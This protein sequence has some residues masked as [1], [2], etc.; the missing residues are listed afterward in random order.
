M[1]RFI[2]RGLSRFTAAGVA[3]SLPLTTVLLSTH[4]LTEQERQGILP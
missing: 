3:S 2:T 1:S 4:W